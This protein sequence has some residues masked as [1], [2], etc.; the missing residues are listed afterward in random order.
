MHHDVQVDEDGDK[1][2]PNLLGVRLDLALLHLVLN[3][4]ALHCRYVK[5]FH[6]CHHITYDG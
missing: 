1:D 5:V 3:Q 2:C 6:L 4:K